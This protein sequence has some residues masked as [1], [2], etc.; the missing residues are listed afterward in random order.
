[1]P[2]SRRFVVDAL[3]LLRTR[4]RDPDLVQR[5][6]SGTQRVRVRSVA[7]R[8][9]WCAWA[10][11]ACSNDVSSTS[12]S[13]SPLTATPTPTPTT[14]TTTTPTTTPTLTTNAPTTSDWCTEGLNA[15]DEATCYVVPEVVASPRVLV[16]YLHGIVAPTGHPQRVVQGIV[17]DN[18]RAHGYVALMPR[19]RRGI[20]PNGMRDWWGWPTTAAAYAKYAA[21]MTSEW[22]DAIGAPFERTYL[23]GSSNGAYFVTTLAFSG[24]FPADGYGAMSGGGRGAKSARSIASVRRAPFYVGYGTFDDG[25]G[26]PIGL[27]ALLAEAG[28]P[29]EIRAHAVGHGARGV[30]LDEALELWGS[31]GGR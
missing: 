5:S 14:T 4:L 15:L 3:R 27:G 28:W 9:A 10:V 20:G 12:T 24:G 22:L 17:A 16:V 25:K 29:Y 6:R 23:A 21:A 2:T 7:T 26:D 1:M 13:T 30:Y 19:G 11:V 18:A 8:F 31:G